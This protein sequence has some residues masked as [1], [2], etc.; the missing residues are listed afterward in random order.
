MSRKA[1]HPTLKGGRAYV[2]SELEGIQS[3]TSE[4][5]TEAGAWYPLSGSREVN[6]GARLTFSS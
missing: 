6:A 2:G 5:G 1:E 3:L 4:E